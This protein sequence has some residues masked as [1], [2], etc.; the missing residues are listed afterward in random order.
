[1]RGAILFA[2]SIAAVSACQDKS[3]KN[4]P[5]PS[6]TTAA[7]PSATVSASA[8]PSVSAAP[9][10]DALPTQITYTTYK[11]AKYGYS[12]EVASIWS[13]SSLF[14]G[15][16]GHEWKLGERALMN[17]AAMEGPGKSIKDWYN[18]ARKE[19]GILGANL[20]EDWFT[21]TGKRDGKIFWQRSVLKNNVL[22]SVRFEYDE[23]LKQY[24]DRIIARASATLRP[25]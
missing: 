13:S 12:I 19:P 8:A 23:I 22:Y 18:E 24:L 1:M 6:A 11:N 9:S 25:S 3:S 5:A 14:L 16:A 21:K 7:A 17:V 4:A 15:D 20:D 2:A 10:G